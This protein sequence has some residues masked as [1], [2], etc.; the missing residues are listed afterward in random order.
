MSYVIEC[1]TRRGVSAGYVSDVRLGLG[2]EQSVIDGV[3]YSMD[4][5]AAKQFTTE[6]EASEA[7]KEISERN[8]IAGPIY[9][10]KVVPA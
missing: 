5:G 3:W 4:R 2:L 1:T 10:M 7:I 9:L 6:Q 8:K